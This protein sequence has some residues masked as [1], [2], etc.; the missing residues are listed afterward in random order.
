MTW[1]LVMPGIEK[2]ESKRGESKG[3]VLAKKA[4][5]N[6]KKPS[7]LLAKLGATAKTLGAS[8]DAK[9]KETKNIP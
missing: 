8:N 7:G 9:S 5:V 6:D 3:R 2:F 1:V 4:T